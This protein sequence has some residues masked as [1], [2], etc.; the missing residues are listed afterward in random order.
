MFYVYVLENAEGDTYV[1]Y[2]SDLKKRL[3]EHNRGHT[4]STSKHTWRCIYYEA[5]LQPEDARR[6]EKYFKT[7]DGRR[8]LRSRLKVHFYQRRQPKSH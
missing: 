5:C 1:G 2:S 6:R 7:T 4:R 8:A 3:A